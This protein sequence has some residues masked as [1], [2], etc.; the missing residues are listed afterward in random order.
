MNPFQS[1]PEY[2]KFIYTLT[3]QFPALQASTLVV[4]RRGAE[5]AIV[6]GELRFQ[7]GIDWTSKNM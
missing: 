5:Y 4:I 7:V 3:E 2:E 6:S 1:L